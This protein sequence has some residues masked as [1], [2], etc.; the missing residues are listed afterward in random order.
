MSCAAVGQNYTE[1][2]GA[3]EDGRS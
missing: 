3:Q 2:L 1:C